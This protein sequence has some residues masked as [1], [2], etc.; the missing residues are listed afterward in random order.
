MIAVVAAIVLLGVIG[1]AEETAESAGGEIH[2]HADGSEHVHEET[3][4]P[5]APPEHDDSTHEH[6]DD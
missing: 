2:V 1:F 3:A 4:E 6:N 5:E